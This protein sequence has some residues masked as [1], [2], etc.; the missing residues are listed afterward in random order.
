MVK[1]SGGLPENFDMK[2]SASDLMTPPPARLSGYLDPAPKI[3]ELTR[4]TAQVA[5]VIEKIVEVTLAPTTNFVADSEEVIHAVV[6]QSVSP[7]QEETPVKAVK[8]KEPRPQ[9]EKPERYQVNVTRDIK[10]KTEEILNILSRQSPDDR[11]KVTELFQALILGLYDVRDD[12]NGKLPERGR[13]GAP[14]AKNYSA[15]LAVVLR[16]ALIQGATNKG[17]NIFRR[18]VGE[19]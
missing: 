7:Q 1:K 16:E 9:S 15:E 3:P 11:V 4:V 10:R 18:A 19:S 2:V 13:W 5:P 8:P 17:T 6:P 12:I 14:T